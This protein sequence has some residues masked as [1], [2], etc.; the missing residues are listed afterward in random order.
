MQSKEVSEYLRIR[1]EWV[2][3]YR[4]VY[5]TEFEDDAYVW[6]PL[7][8]KEF[9]EKIAPLEFETDKYDEICKLCLLDPVVEDIDLLP[10]GVPNVVGQE[11]L[12]KAG[13]GKDNTL[14]KDLERQFDVEMRNFENQVSCIIKFCFPEFTLEEIDNWGLE[15]TMWYYSRAKWTLEVLRGVK[16]EEDTEQQHH[17]P[18]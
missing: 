6:R 8:R 5:V 2:K 9:R 12:K 10:A 17:H 1:D 4:E 16:L 18:F 14:M 11:I 13:F 15:K 7:S 3:E